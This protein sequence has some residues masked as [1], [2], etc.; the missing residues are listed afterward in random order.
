MDNGKKRKI[1]NSFRSLN[2]DQ[3]EGTQKCIIASFT[4]Q[5]RVTVTLIKS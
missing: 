3:R 1:N 4:L 2:K 5:K